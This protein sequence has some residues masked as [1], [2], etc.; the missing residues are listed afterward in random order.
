MLLLKDST[1]YS[2]FNENITNPEYCFEKCHPN[3]YK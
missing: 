1:K 3:T 2:V